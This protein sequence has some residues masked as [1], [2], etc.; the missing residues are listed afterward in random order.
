MLAHS[1]Y[2]ARNLEGPSQGIHLDSQQQ[3]TKGL[4]RQYSLTKTRQL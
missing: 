3:D 4:L 2:P 1:T